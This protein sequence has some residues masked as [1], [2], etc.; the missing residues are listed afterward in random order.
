MDDRS[1][2]RPIPT[3]DGSL[4]CRLRMDRQEECSPRRYELLRS[5]PELTEMLEREL[6]CETYREL[7]GGDMKT[8][9]GNLVLQQPKRVDLLDVPGLDVGDSPLR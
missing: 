4:L 8:S 9:L 1:Q 5:Q 6:K 2:Q 7:H 3:R